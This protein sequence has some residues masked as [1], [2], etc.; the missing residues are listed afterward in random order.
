[1][2]LISHAKDKHSCLD[3]RKSYTRKPNLTAHIEKV[4]FNIL[5]LACK[6]PLCDKKFN[7]KWAL[8]RHTQAHTNKKPYVCQ[9]CEK[10]YADNFNLKI[11]TA[12]Q[13]P[14][15]HTLQG[16]M[17]ANKRKFDESDRNINIPIPTETIST[18]PINSSAMSFA[19]PPLV[20]SPPELNESQNLKTLFP[21]GF[22]PSNFQ[23]EPPLAFTNNPQQINPEEPPIQP[24]TVSIPVFHSPGTLFVTPPL[25]FTSLPGFNQTTYPQM[26]FP[27]GF[28]HPFFPIPQNN[29]QPYFTSG[30]HQNKNNTIITSTPA[31]DLSSPLDLLAMVADKEKKYENTDI[32]SNKLFPCPGFKCDKEYA[33]HRSL[34]THMQ[35]KHPGLSAFFTENFPSKSK[36]SAGKASKPKKSLAKKSHVSY[37]GNR[38]NFFQNSSSTFSQGRSALNQPS[39]SVSS[40][41]PN[42]Q[43]S[44]SK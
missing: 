21:F 17:R 44:G 32:K 41:S 25:V 1:M 30:S 35:N 11:H 16:T 39:T 19:I 31:D 22:M 23:N 27:S 13:H 38:D 9:V 29:S 3:C 33:S 15:F 37:F 12:K 4:H 18:P 20:F 8:D 10:G 40:L 14:E 26:L 2:P 43:S 36:I 24:A 34:K 6:V 7:K 5:K 28:I 42:S